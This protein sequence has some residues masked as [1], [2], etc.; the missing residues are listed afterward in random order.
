MVFD[1]SAEALL[2]K[3]VDFLPSDAICAIAITQ[4]AYGGHWLCRREIVL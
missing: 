4:T 1:D 3:K 2:E